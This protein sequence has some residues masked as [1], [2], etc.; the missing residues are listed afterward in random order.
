MAIT[1]GQSAPDFTLKDQSQKE[2]KLSDRGGK[3]KC[4]PGFLSFGLE[5]GLHQRAQ[6]LRE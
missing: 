2:V 1:V 5:P 6:L 4:C 3:E